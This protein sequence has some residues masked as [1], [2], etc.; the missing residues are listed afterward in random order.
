MPALP[1]AAVLGYL[2]TL[3]SL[4]SALLHFPR[5]PPPPFPFQAPYGPGGQ[6]TIQTGQF[7]LHALLPSAVEA[8]KRFVPEAQLRQQ[9]LGQS[10]VG[11]GWMDELSGSRFCDERPRLHADLDWRRYWFL[12]SPQ[13]KRLPCQI[14]PKDGRGSKGEKSLG[15]PSGLVWGIGTLSLL[16]QV[17]L[18]KTYFKCMDTNIRRHTSLFERVSVAT[19]F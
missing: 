11:P 19:K 13:L 5:L 18:W 7:Q 3:T 14:C 1:T 8:A 2:L 15:R 9:A 12:S 4:H 16:Y 6:S 17:H 10:L